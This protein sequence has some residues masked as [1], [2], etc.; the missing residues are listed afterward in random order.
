MPGACRG[1][2]RRADQQAG[3]QDRGGDQPREGLEARSSKRSRSVKRTPTGISPFA[4][5]STQRAAAACSEGRRSATSSTAKVACL[6]AAPRMASLVDR[7]G[8]E[9]LERCSSQLREVRRIRLGHERRRDR[10]GL[11]D[12]LRRQRE[13][14]VEPVA[15]VSEDVDCLRDELLQGSGASGGLID[16]RADPL[17]ELSLEGGLVRF[18]EGLAERA[19]RTSEVGDVLVAKGEQEAG[20]PDPFAA[21]RAGPPCRHRGTSAGR[22]RARRRRCRGA[23]RR[24]RSRRS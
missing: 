18:A 15:G 6:R 3:E 21:G 19:E 5:W 1:G 8:N 12:R 24:G 16:Q 22:S 7:L 2:D 14:G 4:S 9:L 20:E 10:L 17:L 13:L 11:G 23:G